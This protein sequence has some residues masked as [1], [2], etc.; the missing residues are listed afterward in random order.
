MIDINKL[1]EAIYFAAQKHS[2][3]RRKN[4]AKDPYINHP[5][6]V[7]N[8]ICKAGILDVDVL[9]GGVLHDTVEDTNTTYEEIK[10][11]FGL[12]IAN[13]VDDV[14]DNKSLPKIE[15]KKLQIM[16]ASN[17][18]IEAQ[19]VKLADKYSNISN[20]LID[21]PT[22]WTHER[23]IGYVYWGFAVYKKLKGINKYFDDKFTE[24]FENF[25]INVN[26]TDEELNV[27][28]EEYYNL[29]DNKD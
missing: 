9:I 8:L 11:K 13:I 19:Y 22:S 21:P 23:V 14:T 2:S 1:T 16:H 28:L 15:R 4:S 17:V 20:L 26:I 25:N 3:Q 10:N 29:I 5:I 12:K 7:M 18:S 6:E 27:K 24:L